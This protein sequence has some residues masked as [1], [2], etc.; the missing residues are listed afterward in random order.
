MLYSLHVIY[1]IIYR[2]ADL[3]PVSLC[4]RS[5]LKFLSPNLL[6]AFGSQQILF[7]FHIHAEHLRSSIR[8]K[9]PILLSDV[10]TVTNLYIHCLKD[11]PWF[12]QISRDTIDKFETIFRIWIVQEFV[13]EQ[14][15]EHETAV[16]WRQKR[17]GRA[18][19]RPGSAWWGTPPGYLPS[20]SPTAATTHNSISLFTSP[21]DTTHTHTHTS[22]G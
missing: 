1:Y 19:W 14:L 16:P 7:L 10:S 22:A 5:V 3:A 20:C 11:F 13:L 4:T 2:Y 18:C 9:K 6:L 12:R 21:W 15:G 17:S 8:Q